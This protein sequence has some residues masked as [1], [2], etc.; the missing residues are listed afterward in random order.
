M[1]RWYRRV[2]SGG[3]LSVVQTQHDRDAAFSLQ[4]SFAFQEI[5][6]PAGCC[7]KVLCP[8]RSRH[9][10]SKSGRTEFSVQVASKA[11]PQFSAYT[12]RAPGLEKDRSGARM[13]TFPASP[14]GLLKESGLALEVFAPAVNGR[15]AHRPVPERVDQRRCQH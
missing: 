2:S 14:A 1:G 9:L 13:A 6:L 10:H 11:C 12:R 5:A 8:A 7:A 4:T 3:L 15:G